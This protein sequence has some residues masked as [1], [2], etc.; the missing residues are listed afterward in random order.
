MLDA[1]KAGQEGAKKLKKQLGRQYRMYFPTI[2]ED[3]GELN[4]DEITSDI[5]P[6]IEKAGI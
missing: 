1:D 4:Q 3:A 2:K 6:I 5:K